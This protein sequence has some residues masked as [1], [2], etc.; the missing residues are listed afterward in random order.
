MKV[1]A[2]QIRRT[3]IEMLYRARASHLGPSMSVI[4]LLA[5][6]YGKVDLARIRACSPDRD[7]V[8]LSKGHAAAGLYATLWHFNLLDLDPRLHYCREGSPLAGHASHA[9]QA[10][11]HSTGALGHGLPVAV[12]C[13]LGLRSLGHAC[14]RTYVVVGDGEL[15]EGSNWEALMLARH[16]HLS[17]LTILV[18]ANGISSIRPTREVVDLEPLARVFQGFGFAVEE[19]PGSDPDAIRRALDSLEREEVPGVLIARTVKGQ[20]IPFAENQPIWHYRSLNDQLYADAMSA[21]AG[22]APA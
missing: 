13:A 3:A 22:Q 20:G 12:G 17:N 10:V 11:E 14:S 5:A 8:I 21:L 16:H 4:D 1:L 2:N 6:I 15:Q 7:R 9:V 19:T 18:D